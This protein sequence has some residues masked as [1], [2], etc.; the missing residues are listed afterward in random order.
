M[1]TAEHE[2]LIFWLFIWLLV[3]ASVISS[4]WSKK[5]PSVGLPLTYLFNLSINHWFGAMIYSFPWYSPQSSAY[6][7]SQGASMANTVA[8]FQQS[9]YG[10]IG[11]G[12]GSII[13]AP[14][15]L[16]I[17]KPTWLWDMPKQPNL[18]LPKTY[19]SLGLFFYFV[20]SP[21]LSR[22]PSVAA[23]AG[24]GFLLLS[25][26][27]CL[28]C[29]KAWCMGNKKAF[30]SC[31][32]VTCCIPFLSM[33]SA[34]FLSF[35]TGAAVIVLIFVFTFYRPR[36]KLIVI[37]LLVLYFGLS[38][39]VTY[40][41]DREEIRAQV[42]TGKSAESRIEQVWKTMS[43]FEIFSFSEQRHLEI[44]D[45]RM[46]INIIVGL[47]VNYISSGAANFAG[48][49]SLV[50]AVIAAV[51]RILWP[52]KPVSAGSGDLVSR[53]TGIEFPSGTS[54]GVGNVLELYLNF[55]SMGVVLGFFVLGI[56]LRIF[57]LAA[58]Q[59]LLSGNWVG[60]TSW[61][62]PGMSLINPAGSLSEVVSTTTASVVLVFLI[63]RV[64]LKRKG[65]L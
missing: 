23:L 41:R 3:M 21:I 53:Y 19:I 47:A 28:A 44:I 29:W 37:T 38:V 58:G 20:L 17:F 13:F 22:I 55:G 12:F 64:Y 32:A 54:V 56:L 52:G 34:G 7:I 48:G 62:I 31:L 26:G 4:M 8:G 25:V 35:G 36:W 33:V 61:F 18:K 39:M 1:F 57:D 2:W 46:N 10:V 65:Q 5:L 43:N 30:L 59:R 6:L 24:S 16:K 27:L 40:F 45:G 42:W 14:W 60:F 51:P 63:N 11:F 15:L 9:V 50:Q 49:E